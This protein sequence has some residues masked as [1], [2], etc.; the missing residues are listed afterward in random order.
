MCVERFLHYGRRMYKIVSKRNDT[1][2][3]LLNLA[4]NEYTLGEVEY[5]RLQLQTQFRGCEENLIETNSSE[6]SHI[7]TYM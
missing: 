6:L 4:T 2:V 1:S 5:T 7:P 3:E